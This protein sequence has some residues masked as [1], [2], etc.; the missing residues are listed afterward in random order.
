MKILI[1]NGP[2]LNLLGQRLPS[3]YGHTTWFD[4]MNELKVVNKDTELFDFQSNHEGDLIDQI[5]SAERNFDAI[6]LNAAAFTHTSIAI[7]DAIES[8]KVPVLEVHIS[9]IYKREEFRQISLLAPVC[10]GQISGLGLESYSLAVQYFKNYY[11]K[12][13]S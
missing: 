2:N 11:D 5:Q 9:N 12:K 13:S 1:I 3:V 10:I 7:R 8:I 6:I 4:Y